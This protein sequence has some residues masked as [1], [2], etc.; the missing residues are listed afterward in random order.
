MRAT[1]SSDGASARRARRRGGRRIGRRRSARSH[2]RPATRVLDAEPA[3]AARRRP[4]L[5]DAPR[6][7]N[8]QRAQARVA[9]A[10]DE[11]AHHELGER[12]LELRGEQANAGDD[13]VEERRAV[14]GEEVGDTTRARAQAIVAGGCRREVGPERGGA[15]RQQQDRRRPQRRAAVASDLARPGTQPRPQRA[16]G[17]AQLVEPARRVVGH[18]R[19]Q[20]LGLP[21]RRRR[22]VAFELRQH[23]GERVGPAD[24]AARRDVLPLEQE[25]REIARLDRLDLAPQAAERVAMDAR[26]QMALAPLDRSTPMPPASKRPCRT[27]PSRCSCEQRRLDLCRRR[28]RAARRD[29]R[30]SSARARR[31]ASAAARAARRRDRCR[32]PRN[33]PA[34]R[35]TAAAWPADAARAAAAAAPPRPRGH[36]LARATSTRV[37]RRAAASASSHS[38]QPA[39]AATSSS[40]DCAERGER[41]VHLVDVARGAARLRRARWRSPLGRGGRGRRPAR[42]RR[43]AG[44]EPPACAAPRAARR[45]GRRTAARSALRRRTATAPAGRARRPRPRPPS[46]RAQQ[47]AASRARPSPPRGNRARSARPADARESRARRRGSRRT[48]PGRGR[49]RRAGPRRACAAAAARPCGRR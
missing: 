22:L 16:A 46:M 11:T 23:A 9:V 13:V 31:G 49:L 8:E 3:G 20:Q 21:R 17:G 39:S 18:P 32:S 6:R 36:A 14:R 43:S 38:P 1:C 30:P 25:A 40:R 12:V 29:R 10:V 15:A 41:F 37:A 4:C 42:D 24:A 27:L 19:R 44:C 35:P 7:R 2:Q 5:R 45:R 47:R 28:H 48:R 34:P 26:Q 33:R